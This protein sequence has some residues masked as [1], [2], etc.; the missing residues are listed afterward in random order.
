M[1]EVFKK[2]LAELK[3]EHELI[4]DIRG[5][6]LMLGVDLVKDRGTK[7]PA[8]REVLKVCWR[9]WE[10]GLIITNLGQSVLRI[11]PPLNI[12][13]EEA[14]QA[15]RIIDGALEDTEQGRVPDEVLKR[16]VGW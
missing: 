9:C 6:G 11:A 2:R 3:E 15:L 13:D 16:M 8:R 10:K 7:E 1:E 4:G 5:K 14:D 12:T